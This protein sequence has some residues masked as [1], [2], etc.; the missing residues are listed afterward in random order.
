MLIIEKTWCV[1][2]GK[3]ELSWI[4]FHKSKSILK[5]SIYFKS[6]RNSNFGYIQPE[7]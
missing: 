2:Y 1:V 3:A 6:K 4:V 5:L 7:N